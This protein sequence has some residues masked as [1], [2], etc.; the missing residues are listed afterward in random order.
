MEAGKQSPVQPSEP[1]TGQEYGKGEN[2]GSAANLAV[3]D[4][5]GSGSVVQKS[6]KEL[7]KIKKREDKGMGKYMWCCSIFR[8]RC[9]KH[10]IQSS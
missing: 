7:A 8:Y 10:S 9:E 4:F 5:T 6:S 3:P 2:A 1:I